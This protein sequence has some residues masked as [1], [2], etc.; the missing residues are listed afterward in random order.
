MH[1]TATEY[2]TTVNGVTAYKGNN[3][4]EAIRAWDHET[5]TGPHTGGITVQQWHDDTMVR[6]GWILHVRDN[7]VVYLNPKVVAV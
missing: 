7:G 1:T 2:V 4:K 6:D 3:L 5:F